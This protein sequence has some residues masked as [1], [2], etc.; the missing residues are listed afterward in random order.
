MFAV[1]C[2]TMENNHF[3]NKENLGIDQSLIDSYIHR[4]SDTCDVI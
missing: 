4:R 2:L 1:N 3:V